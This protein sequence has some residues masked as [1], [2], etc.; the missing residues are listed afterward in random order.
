[1]QNILNKFL[2][3]FK[4]TTVIIM[5]IIST[6]SLISILYFAFKTYNEMNNVKIYNDKLSIKMDK[7]IIDIE[8][9]KSKQID[10]Y[11]IKDIAN[12]AIKY[13]VLEKENKNND[14]I[15]LNVKN[16][17]FLIKQFINKKLKIKY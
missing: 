11:K 4:N 14:L 2:E 10:E 9:L 16:E 8:L 7:A 6:C 3:Y 5:L 17:V 15:K 12:D 1:M 13:Y